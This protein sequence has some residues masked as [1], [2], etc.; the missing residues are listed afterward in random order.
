M[1]SAKKNFQVINVTPKNIQ[2]G[3]LDVI[4][5]ASVTITVNGEV[6]LTFMCTPFDMEALAVGFLFNEGIIDTIEELASVRLCPEGDNIDV[7]LEH[8]VAKPQ[9]WSKTSGCTGGMTSVNDEQFVD[10]GLIAH[11]SDG[12]IFHASRVFEWIEWLHQAQ[13]LY[14]EAGGVHTSA[15]IDGESI[16]FITEDIGRHNTLDKIAGRCLLENVNPEHKIIITTGR[17]SSEML[18]KATRIG[19][20]II[21]SRTSPTS[22]SIELA[23]RYGITLIGYARRDRFNIYTHPQRILQLETPEVNHKFFS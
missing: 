3:D 12:A 11:N 7:W 16:L 23:E 9:T 8:Y 19:A 13:G 17:V 5:E 4:S 6:W 21:V 22:L 18:H 1:K 2:S 14:R 15:L 10:R 20:S